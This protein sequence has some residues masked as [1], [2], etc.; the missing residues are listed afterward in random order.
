MNTWQASSPEVNRYIDPVPTITIRLNHVVLDTGFLGSITSLIGSRSADSADRWTWE[1]W[2]VTNA[3]G[4][5]YQY[6]PSTGRPP[7]A[8]H[9]DGSRTAKI[10]MRTTPAPGASGY[11]L[12]F[13]LADGRGT[14][15][16]TAPEREV[17][18]W[19]DQ[20]QEALK[21]YGADLPPFKVFIGHGG[22]GQWQYLERTLRAQGYEVEN[23]EADDRAGY[24]TLVV[25]EKIIRSSAV[26][27]I[28]MTGEDSMADGSLRAREN[29]VHEVGFAQGILGIENTIILLE[30]HVSEPSNITGLTQIRFRRGRLID[31][32]EAILR[33]LNK[34]RE[35]SEYDQR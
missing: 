26:A 9:F 28:V 22:D 13:D 30:E 16:A 7:L 1:D 31:A 17:R 32:E 21:A 29:V 25:I 35:A 18:A 27:L 24:H 11:E 14:V 20:V 3:E 33:S 8:A 10:H 4:V 15:R 19:A 5:E 23:F 6:D 12:A 2:H 34:R